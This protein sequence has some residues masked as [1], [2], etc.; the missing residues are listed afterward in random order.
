MKGVWHSVSAP[1]RDRPVAEEEEDDN[2][3]DDDRDEEDDDHD[4]DDDDVDDEDYRWSPVGVPQCQRPRYKQ[5]D[6]I[7]LSE[8]G[9]HFDISQIVHFLIYQNKCAEIILISTSFSNFHAC[10]S[11]SS[12]KTH[13]RNDMTYY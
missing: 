11:L 6:P 13:F 8:P 5:D 4:E 3:D 9:S 12:F 1:H 7:Q 10:S 2:Q